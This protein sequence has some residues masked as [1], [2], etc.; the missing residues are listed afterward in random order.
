[1][2]GPRDPSPRFAVPVDYMTGET[3]S[4]GQIGRIYKLKEA[5]ETLRDIMHDCEGSDHG[6]PTFQSRRMAVANT[7][8]EMGMLMAMR[9]ALEAK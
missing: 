2:T 6:N 7:Q 8:I 4:D 9:A 1:M 3:L 5:Y